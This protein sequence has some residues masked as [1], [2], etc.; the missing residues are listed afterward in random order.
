MNNDIIY[1]LIKLSITMFSMLPRTV[2]RFFSDLLGL[3]W[4]KADKRHRNV[5]LENINFAY[6]EQ[7]SSAQTQRFVKNVFKHIANIL[8]EVI[9]SYRKTRK[10]LFEYFTVKGVRHIE[11]AQKKGRG[12]ILLSGHIGNFELCSAAVAKV[13]IAPYG[14]YRKFDFQPL[15]R[16]VLKVRQRFGTKMIPLK[17]ASKKID[18]ILKN[19][20][21][22]GTLLDQ[23]VDWYDGVFVDYF[24]RT[25]CTNKGLAKLVLRSKA[26]VI[27]MFMVKKNKNYIL[28]FLPEIP[29]QIT[30]DNI[31]DL[32]NN[33]QNYVAA[34]E[35]M[36]RKCPE[37][38][39]WVH[40]RWKTKS[41]CNFPQK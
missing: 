18:I 16:F 31:K 35:S 3:I 11:N 27:P 41:Y 14:V 5:A 36:V 34:I 39:F 26:A 20:G 9:W 1:K 37:Q 12:V 32:E 7:F 6:P 10:D 28:E 17:G 19:N 25:T 15:E 4:Y 24:G 22:V 23:N 21:V 8:F 38:Y 33:T 40:N 30:G 2:L 29:L 13:G